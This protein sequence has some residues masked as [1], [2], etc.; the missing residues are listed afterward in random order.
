MAVRTLIL[1]TAH[2][3]LAIAQSSTLQIAGWQQARAGVVQ[4]AMYI[5]GGLR[6]VGNWVNNAWTNVTIPGTP[7]GSLYRLSFHQP[8]TADQDNL[9]PIFEQ[10]NETTDGSAPIFFGGTMF[11]DKDEFYTFGCVTSMMLC[12][13]C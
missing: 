2:T 9:L 8:W 4:D 12:C 1:V 10:L 11:A 3:A 5:E 7:D 6:S 13:R